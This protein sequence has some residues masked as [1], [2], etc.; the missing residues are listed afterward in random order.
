MK[1]RR[2]PSGALTAAA[3]VA[4]GL[5]ACTSQP[6]VRSVVNDSIETLE[7]TPQATKDCMLDVVEG[8]TDEQSEQMSSDNPG[9]NSANPDLRNATPE[10]QEFHAA[11]DDCAAQG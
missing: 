10:F 6:S 8:Y 1:F 9:F 7:T 2:S 3:V 11:L 4:L 5:G